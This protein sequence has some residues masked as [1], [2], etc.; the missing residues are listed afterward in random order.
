MRDELQ[1]WL[2]GELAEADLPPELRPEAERLRALLDAPRN[3]GPAPAW[4][5]ARVMTAL[6][7]PRAGVVRRFAAWLVEPKAIRLRPATVGA[8]A[9]AV[10]ATILLWPDAPAPGTGPLP[11]QTAATGPEDDRV[12]VQFL[13]VAPGAASVAVAGDFNEWRPDD[14]HLTDPDGDGI[15]TGR[16]ALSPGL[17]KYMFVVDGEWVTDPLAERYVDDGFG[18]HNALID[19]T[20]SGSAI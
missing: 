2:D 5:E 9:A 4:I 11:V 10:L 17:H 1:Q 15:W 13:Y 16:L 19:V 6:P 18:N 3:V 8:L 7:E 14:V 20:R 12:Y